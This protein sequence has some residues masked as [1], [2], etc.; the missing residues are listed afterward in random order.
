MGALVQTAGRA[1]A[2]AGL[3]AVAGAALDLLRPDGALRA[4][5][6]VPPAMCGELPAVL[7]PETIAVEQAAALCAT[8]QV[9]IA[10]ARDAARFA[11]GH[12]AGAVHL[13]CAASGE[14]L[15][16]VPALLQDT[17]MVLVYADSTAEALAVADGLRRRGAPGLRVVVLEGGFAAW[18][19]S[20][21]ACLSG[22]CPACEEHGH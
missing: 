5:A 15:A 20:G 17:R 8:G 14:V 6:A 19:R 7:P 16:R 1:A 10:D 3:A 4:G 11:R 18:E 21:H 13:P 9:L 22:A 12:I 2:L